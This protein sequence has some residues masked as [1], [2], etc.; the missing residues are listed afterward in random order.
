MNTRQ[1]EW[2]DTFC[3]CHV[4][5]I[6][7]ETCNW[8]WAFCWIPGDCAVSWPSRWHRSQDDDLLVYEVESVITVLTMHNVGFTVGTK[9][10]EKL[11]NTSLKPLWGKDKCFNP[12]RMVLLLSLKFFKCLFKCFFYLLSINIRNNAVRAEAKALIHSPT[13]SWLKT[14]SVLNTTVWKTSEIIEPAQECEAQLHLR[15]L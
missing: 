4:Q 7:N 15:H 13:I 5:C 8:S 3:Y 9:E 11:N 2:L 10:L 1:Y 14:M 12:W 6:V